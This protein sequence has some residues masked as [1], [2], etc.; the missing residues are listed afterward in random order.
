L[1]KPKYVIDNVKNV[2]NNFKKRYMKLY[3]SGIYDNERADLTGIGYAEFAIQTVQEDIAWLKSTKE[4][5]Q[6]VLAS[7]DMLLLIAKKFPDDVYSR[8]SEKQIKEWN[9]VFDEWFNRVN[10]KIPEKYRQKI[11]DDAVLLF[12]KLEKYG[13]NFT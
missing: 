10:K 3:G 6:P 5:C 13:N 12:K 7:I 1:E 8:L 11:F 9:M 2:I 4:I